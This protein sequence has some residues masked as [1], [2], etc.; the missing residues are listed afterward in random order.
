MFFFS[1]SG[2]LYLRALLVLSILI[3]Y[4]GLVKYVLSN[5]PPEFQLLFP[6]ILSGN[7]VIANRSNNVLQLR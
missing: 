2:K 1:W 5:P 3:C 6:T 4:R 7:K